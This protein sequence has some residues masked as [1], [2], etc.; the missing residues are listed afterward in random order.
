MLIAFLL[1]FSSGLPLLL[2]GATLQV[3]FRESGMSLTEIGFFALIGIP[4]TVK[5]LWS[6]ILD[7]LVPPFLGRRRGWLLTSQLSMM[8]AMFALSFSNPKDGLIYM[9][10]MAFLVAF[11]SA[12]Q[13]I[14]I[15]AYI[16][17]LI[18]SELYGLGSQFYVLG[19]R[20]AMI[21]AS[22]GALFLAD[23]LPWQTVYQVMAL[24][25]LVGVFTT[26][27]S[28]E[29]TQYGKPIRSLREAVVDP[30]RDFFSASGSLKGY[31]WWVLAFF[32]TYNLAGNLTTA[33]S[34]IFYLDLGYTK[35]EI[36]ATGK[37]VGIWA[38]IVGGLVGGSIVVYIG[39]RR[40]LWIFGI[41]QGFASFSY[42]WLF[43][44]VKDIGQ[45]SLLALGAA[46]TIENMVIG[47]CTAA[48]T[49]YMGLTVNKRF[50]ATQYALLSS[51]MGAT[52]VYISTPTGWLVDQMGW[53]M[54]YVFCAF[55]AIPGLFVLY[56]LDSINR[57]PE[58]NGLQARTSTS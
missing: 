8:A 36:A 30:I 14:A 49:A 22:A 25:I 13:D 56:K 44:L 40:A 12:T 45:T 21:A 54:F 51:L 48:Y 58:Y 19:Y 7:W 31:A 5:F 6:P 4:Y 37:L 9:T 39:V 1:G 35:T 11:L 50:T 18:P 53:P 34:S 32:V 33:L 24:L 41:L 26:L 23:I 3:W 43:H 46:I 42:F 16:I 57:S 55:S 38:T 28:R 17:E 47:M 10:F 27:L 20:I 29:P 52:R 15:D 2:T